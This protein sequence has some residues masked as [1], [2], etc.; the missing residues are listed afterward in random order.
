MMITIKRRSLVS[1]RVFIGVDVAA[2]ETLRTCMQ[3]IIHHK[4]E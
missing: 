2:V 3:L 1:K 4:K